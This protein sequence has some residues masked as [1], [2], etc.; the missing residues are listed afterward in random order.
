MIVESV[1]S[2]EQ[3]CVLRLLSAPTR[4]APV[5]GRVGPHDTKANAPPAAHGIGRAPWP[6]YDLRFFG[7]CY[8]RRADLLWTGY[9]RH[10]PTL[11]FVCRSHPQGRET[12]RPAG[13]SA[14]Q[15]RVGDQS[16]NREDAWPRC[17]PGAA[18]PRRRGDRI[19]MPDRPLQT[20]LIIL[21]QQHRSRKE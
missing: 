11:G 7:S 12:C 3:F 6:P 4:V 2:F 15:I 16:Q 14:N 10:S 9:C 21:F 18:R 17:A 1:H 5:T 19:A 13:A 20:P 8:G